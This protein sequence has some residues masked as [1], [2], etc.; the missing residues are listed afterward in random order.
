MRYKNNRK[1]EEEKGVLCVGR[2]NKKKYRRF[3]LPRAEKAKGVNL[4]SK[5][6]NSLHLFSTTF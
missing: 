3:C 5:E 2:E 4:K 1:E 6:I